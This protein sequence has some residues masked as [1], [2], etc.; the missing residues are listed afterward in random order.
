V[1]DLMFDRLQDETL[2]DGPENALVTPD[3]SL[4]RRRL[5]GGA[6]GFVLAA[7]G[8]LL[9]EGV[10]GVERQR[11][12]ERI[13]NDPRE[14]N[15]KDRND[16]NRNDK[17]HNK[18]DRNRKDRNQCRCSTG[19][20]GCNGFCKDVE[21]NF[22][23]GFHS[24]SPT[25][26][27]EVWVPTGQGCKD[28]VCFKVFTAARMVPPVRQQAKFTGS[29]DFMAMVVIG[30]HKEIGYG[31]VT[32]MVQNH[33]VGAPT[34]KVYVGGFEGGGPYNIRKV[35]F[36]GGVDEFQQKRVPGFYVDRGKDSAKHKIFSINSDT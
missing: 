26:T 34:L 3:P 27:L 12:V 16:R 20:R 17:N 5:L 32:F 13:L 24:T 8:L 4:S 1:D 35:Y 10:E 29:D 31:H 19:L 23:S 28:G 11:P 30:E 14:R 21:L 6:G 7:S 33:G 36:E 18:N 22:F 2:S 9:P 25:Y 15:R